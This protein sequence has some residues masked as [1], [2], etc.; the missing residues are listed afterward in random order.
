MSIKLLEKERCCQNCRFFGNR[1]GERGD[2]QRYPPQAWA[3]PCSETTNALY[4]SFPEMMKGDW[5]GEFQPI[6]G[7]TIPKDF[8]FEEKP[9]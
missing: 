9:A 4:F 3:D 5:C 6:E 1:H 8:Q 7:W 2:C